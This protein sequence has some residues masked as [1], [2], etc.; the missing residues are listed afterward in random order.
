LNWLEA[1]RDRIV[2]R[3]QVGKGKLDA[4][5]MRR[6]LD[7]RLMELGGRFLGLVHA[8][9]TGVPQE[10]SGLVEEAR[11]LEERLEAQREL[12]AVLK[13]QES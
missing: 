13:S 3:S 12:I 8:G 5:R 2:V 11:E 10:L 1:L 9:R 4:V 6:E 7:R